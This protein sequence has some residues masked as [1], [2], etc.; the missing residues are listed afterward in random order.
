M[1]ELKISIIV[2]NSDIF[3]ISIHMPIQTYL[4]LLFYLYDFVVK[5]KFKY[6]PTLHL[7]VQFTALSTVVAV[8]TAGYVGFM[9]EYITTYRLEFSKDCTTFNNASDTTVL[10]FVIL[11]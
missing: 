2:Q 5:F 6:C 8:Q 9:V 1:M 3:P 7:K 4:H 10:P 11:Y